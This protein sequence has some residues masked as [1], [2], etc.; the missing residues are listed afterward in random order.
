MDGVDF[1]TLGIMAVVVGTIHGIALGIIHGT[2]DGVGIM[3]H[4]IVLGTTLGM[5]PTHI[6]NTLTGMS[7]MVKIDTTPLLITADTLKGETLQS[8]KQGATAY[9]TTQVM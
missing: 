6:H 9:L 1:T 5:D 2:M 4:G 3:I 7:F 8:I